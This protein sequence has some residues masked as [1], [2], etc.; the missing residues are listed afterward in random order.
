METIMN[1]LAKFKSLF[2]KDTIPEIEFP[3]KTKD[4]YLKW[5]IEW[6]TEYK[7]LSDEQRECKKLIRQP[8]EIQEHK[9][10]WGSY[11]TSNMSETQR[12]IAVNRV[13]LTKLLL[14]RT[15]GKKA[16]WKMKQAAE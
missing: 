14:M 6:K 4:E 16:S 12:Q 13:E 11:F 15:E 2:R 7:K 3:F 5:V 10:S 8:H 1:I 9:S